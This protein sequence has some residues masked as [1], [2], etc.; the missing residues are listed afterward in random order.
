M[1]VEA[2]YDMG[3]QRANEELNAQIYVSLMNK[4]PFRV[5]YDLAGNPRFVDIA[6]TESSVV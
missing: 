3:R 1:G 4:K 6:N 5:E 2:P